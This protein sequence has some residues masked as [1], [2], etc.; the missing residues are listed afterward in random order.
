MDSTEDIRAIQKEVA[1]RTHRMPLGGQAG[2][3]RAPKMTDT[4]IR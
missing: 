1:D 3:L 2:Y 4:S